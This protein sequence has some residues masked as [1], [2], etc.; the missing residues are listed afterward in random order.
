MNY[1]QPVLLDEVLKIFNPQPDQFY[2]DATLGEGGHTLCF[3][4]HGAYVYGLDQDKENLKLATQRIEDA[5]FADHFTPIH[6]NFNQLAAIY[7]KYINKPLSG[8]LFDLGLSANQLKFSDKG[9]SFQ[10]SQPL[11]MRLTPQSHLTAENIINTYD[12]PR[13]FTLFSKTAQVKYAKPLILRIIRQ[14]QKQPI[15][16]AHRLA[17]IIKSYY[18]DHHLNFDSEPSTTIFLALRIAVN[19]EYTHL[20]NA[21]NQ[22]LQILQPE[23]GAAIISFHSGEDRIVKNFIRQNQDLFQHP[24]P[25]AIQPRFTETKQNRLARSAILRSYKI[26]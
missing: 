11:D 5:G 8:V 22:T 19:H 12:F 26:K 17:Q 2:L 6:G 21:L 7:S 4:N 16:S 25:K 20:K 1:H 24:I 23:S 18:Q 14:R 10:S 9:F 13:L 3:L 15:K